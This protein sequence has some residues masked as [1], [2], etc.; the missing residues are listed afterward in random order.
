MIYLY[1]YIL[2]VNKL[3]NPNNN[4]NIKCPF[5]NNSPIEYKQTANSFNDYFCNIGRKLADNINIRNSNNIYNFPSKLVNNNTFFFYPT[6]KTE[7][8]NIVENSKN[9]KSNDLFHINM[10][11]LKKTIYVISPILEYLFNLSISKGKFPNIL[12]ISKVIPLFKNGDKSN[13]TNYRPMSLISQFAKIFEKIIKIRM[14][15]FIDKYDL[16]HKSQFGFQKNIDTS[17]AIN[18]LMNDLIGNLEKKYISSIVSIDL[19]KAFDTIN[20][21][22]L[23][24]K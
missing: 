2:V 8:I 22:I 3:L 21:D 11:I 15:S 23:L 10:D 17:V 1:I 13:I 14:I 20:H 19:K 6:N 7:I 16:I 9:K 18:M 5:N 24:N 4:V 12:K